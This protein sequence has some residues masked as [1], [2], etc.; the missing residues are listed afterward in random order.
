LQEIP[1]EYKD[2][3]LLTVVINIF[4]GVKKHNTLVCVVNRMSES[5]NH[6]HKML[7]ILSGTY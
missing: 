7:S 6:S 1:I 3:D 5:T 2:K 4:R